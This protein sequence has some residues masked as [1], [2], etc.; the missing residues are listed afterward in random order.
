M[1]TLSA[2]G[3]RRGLRGLAVQGAGQG[4]AGDAG[5]EGRRADSGLEGRRLASVG[6]DD[7][8]GASGLGDIGSTRHAVDTRDGGL[9]RDGAGD[10]AAGE[11]R[12]PGA[13]GNGASITSLISVAA[14][15]GAGRGAIGIA[16]RG[17]RR[18]ARRAATS[19]AVHAA[20]GRGG[21]GGDASACAEAV[22]PADG[23]VGLV[24]AAAGLDR[25]VAD[26]VVEVVGLAHA[27][28]IIGIATEFGSLGEHVPAAGFTALGH[29]GGEVNS[30]H[31]D[32]ASEGED[33][34][35]A[36]LHCEGWYDLKAC[37]FGPSWFDVSRESGE[38]V[39]LN[40]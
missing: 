18:A 11:G 40:R 32:S 7:G 35:D 15:A 37:S 25:A 27:S 3:A 19:G 28:D 21:T 16:A 39:Q 17:G 24:D 9:A 5:S 6:R 36:G 38:R 4:I 10:I 1:G 22:T 33:S 23:D 34:G 14:G 8:R 26:T 2:A 30:G 13:G 20:S 31:G 29:V 12:G